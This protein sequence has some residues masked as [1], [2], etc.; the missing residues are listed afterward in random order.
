MNEEDTTQER[1]I[2]DYEIHIAHDFVAA[3]PMYRLST[4]QYDIFWAMVG[5]MKRGGHVEATLADIGDR[6]NI[7]ET[8]VSQALKRLRELGMLW[9][10]QPGLYR[11]NPMIG[12]KGPPA[13]WIQAMEELPEDAPMVQVPQYKRRPPRVGNALGPR[14]VA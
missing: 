5:M 12:Y 6:L 7:A 14:A 9:R 8:N 1:T 2:D 11:I 13:E 3:L 4:N 10:V